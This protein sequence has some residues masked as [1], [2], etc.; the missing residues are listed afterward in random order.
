MAI[1]H[2]AVNQRLSDDSKYERRRGRL[3]SEDF[4]AFRRRK[5]K[6]YSDRLRNYC[7]Q[8]AAAM[9]QLALRLGCGSIVL[10]RSGECRLKSGQFQ[11]FAFDL[12][13]K[14]S[15]T[16]RGIK[17]DIV[18]PEAETKNAT[19]ISEEDAVV[20]EKVHSDERKDRQIKCAKRAIKQM[21][22]VKAA[23]TRAEKSAGRFAVG[24]ALAM[25]TLSE[26]TTT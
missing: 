13:L 8:T 15:A 10:D 18:L 9:T 19:L 26:V 20:Q 24:T 1:A 4:Q 2:K 25:E 12:A 17:V 16:Y 6:A 23:E 11:W 21:G 3:A 22:A 5:S 7:C 14:N